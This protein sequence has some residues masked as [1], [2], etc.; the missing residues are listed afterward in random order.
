VFQWML[1]FS[2]LPV[3]V[4]AFMSMSP[5]M[6]HVHVHAAYPSQCCMSASVLHGLEH[7]AWTWTWKYIHEKNQRPK[8]SCH[9][10]PTSE[11]SKRN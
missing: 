2:I 8:I 5:F 1:H 6:L 3:H 10:P 7:V 9:Y 4:H 11:R